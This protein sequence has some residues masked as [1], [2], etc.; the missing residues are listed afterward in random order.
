MVNTFKDIVKYKQPELK[1]MIVA[2]LEKQGK[3]KPLVG[4]GFIYA[5]GDI[6]VMLVAHMDTVHKTPVETIYHDQEQDVIWSPQGIGGDDRCG[7]Y[8]ILKIIAT[9]K[10]YILFTEDEEIGCVGAEKFVTMVQQPSIDKIKYIIELDRRGKKDCVF[11]QCGNKEFQDYVE[12]FGFK[13]AYG[14]YSD[15][16]TISDEWEIASVNLSVGYYHEHTLQEVVKFKQLE[17][18]IEKVITMLDDANNAE[19]YDFEREISHYNIY[20]NYDDYNWGQN[21]FTKYEDK[22]YYNAKTGE[23]VEKN[24]NTLD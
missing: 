19:Y 9:H 17:K 5:E 14:S 16:C 2:Y 3:Y 6:P 22:T 20:N 21:G 15:I 12:G 10:P 13:K 18:T 7:V 4:D 24:D 8:A 1:K 23:I 11:Y